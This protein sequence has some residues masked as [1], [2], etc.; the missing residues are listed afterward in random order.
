MPLRVDV[1]DVVVKVVNADVNVVEV[2]L[3]VEILGV[4]VVVL[5]VGHV[6]VSPVVVEVG[7]CVIVVAGDDPNVV[8]IV[9]LQ[10]EMESCDIVEACPTAS[11][12]GACIVQDCLDISDTVGRV[13]KVPLVVGAC[14]NVEHPSLEY[15]ER[16]SGNC[17][18]SPRWNSVRRNC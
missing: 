5:E 2:P 3:V 13:P 18:R 4:D 9:E 12:A 16:L 6:G 14:K 15:C 8:G 11:S 1:K 10:A 7:V 17:S